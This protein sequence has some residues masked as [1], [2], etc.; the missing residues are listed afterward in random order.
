[1]MFMNSEG[2]YYVLFNES[3]F[4]N[5]WKILLVPLSQVISAI[6]TLCTNFQTENFSG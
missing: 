3:V 5:P 1:M 4:D 2:V 6:I